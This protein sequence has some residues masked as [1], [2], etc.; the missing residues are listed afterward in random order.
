MVIFKESRNPAPNI[1][2]QRLT[3]WTHSWS[4][5]LWRVWALQ[6]QSIN[7][8][9][10]ASTLPGLSTEGNY[11]IGFL[12]PRLFSFVGVLTPHWNPMR[13]FFTVCIAFSIPATLT[14]TVITSS[15]HSTFVFNKLF[16]HKTIP[17]LCKWH[18]QV[19]HYNNPL[20]C[21]FK[22]N[23]SYVS[24]YSDYQNKGN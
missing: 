12:L 20:W 4:S 15:V 24:N 6:H 11:S 19:H 7:Q 10:P 16:P 3:S 18:C 23:I 17:K 2:G 21:H 13:T 9:T 14:S 8:K 22:I 5:G 1:I